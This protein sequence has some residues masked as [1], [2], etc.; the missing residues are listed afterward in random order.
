MVVDL[1]ERIYANCIMNN[2]H[3]PELT[4]WR[5]NIKRQEL[6]KREARERFKQG[7]GNIKSAALGKKKIEEQ[8]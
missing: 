4:K 7:N 3:R 8:R 6:R 2:I 1:E 5:E